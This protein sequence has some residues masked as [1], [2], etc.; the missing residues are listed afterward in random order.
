[1]IHINHTR[2]TRV[3]LETQLTI[4]DILY[5][6]LFEPSTHFQCMIRSD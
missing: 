5:Y 1:M 2:F 4:W 3:S 6:V